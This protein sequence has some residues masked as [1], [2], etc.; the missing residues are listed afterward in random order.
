MQINAIIK[1]GAVFKG[2][3]II[4]KWFVWEGRKYNVKSL[5]Y[6]WSD[7][8]GQEKIMRFSVSDGANTYEL[9]YNTARMS[10]TLDKVSEQ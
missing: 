7:Q 4:P 8:Q 9:A 2:S 3:N 10:W 6:S 1:V 5:D